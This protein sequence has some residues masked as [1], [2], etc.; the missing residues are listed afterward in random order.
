MQCPAAC[1]CLTRVTTNWDITGGTLAPLC[2]ACMHVCVMMFLFSALS[3]CVLPCPHV[4]TRPHTYSRVSS[5]WIRL[6]MRRPASL[7]HEC[8]PKCKHKGEVPIDSCRLLHCEWAPGCGHLWQLCTQAWLSSHKYSWSCVIRGQTQM[9]RAFEHLIMAS[10]E[11]SL[12]V[13]W[14]PLLAFINPL[15]NRILPCLLW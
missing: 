13:L 9:T 1:S 5:I 8:R 15:L 2:S 11:K 10:G 12:L 3:L 7:C 14:V 6:D 4:Y